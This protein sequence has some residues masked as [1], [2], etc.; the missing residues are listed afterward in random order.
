[1]AYFAELDENDIVKRVI[2]AD[3]AF[4][5]SNC[6]GDPNCW[7]ETSMHG[8]IRKNGAGKGYTYDKVR[9]AFIAPKPYTSWTLNEETC[10]WE[11]PKKKPQNELLYRWVE[12][13]QE[14]VE[15]KF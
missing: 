9:D 13:S 14:W 3:Q 7:V 12:D 5:D 10:Q 2:V 8:E 11:P 15:F 1:M 4:I 6:V